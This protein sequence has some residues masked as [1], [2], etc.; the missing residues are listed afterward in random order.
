[1]DSAS[2][3]SSVEV[4]LMIILAASGINA[5]GPVHCEF[6][7]HE[8]NTDNPGD[9]AF[10]KMEFIELRK[11]FFTSNREV[12]QCKLKDYLL[13][14]VKEYSK[15]N[16]APQIVFSASF[17]HAKVTSDSNFFVI[18]SSRVANVNLKFDDAGVS[19]KTKARDTYTAKRTIFFP[20][21]NVLKNGNNYS[22][23][24]VIL[25][26]QTDYSRFQSNG[27]IAALSL[28]KYNA[29]TKRSQYLEDKTVTEDI[30]E[31]IYAHT[32]DMLIYARHTQFN[33][34]KFFKTVYERFQNYH[35][36]KIYPAREFD[37]TKHADLSIN[38][39]PD[40]LDCDAK[41]PLLLTNWKLGNVTPGTE[42]DCSGAHWL[43]EKEIKV[44]VDAYNNRT[45][46]YAYY[47]TENQTGPCFSSTTDIV[48]L[49]AIRDIE[50]DIVNNRDTAVSKGTDSVSLAASDSICRNPSLEAA[51][52]N[53]NNNINYLVQ[54]IETVKSLT[55]SKAC[56]K[57][58]PKRR[59]IDTEFVKPWEDDSQFQPQWAVQLKEYLSDYFDTKW[60]DHSTKTWMQLRID[61]RSPN[62]ATVHC[63]ICNQ[64]QSQKIFLVRKS[65][66]WLKVGDMFSLKT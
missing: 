57:A 54:E 15:M 33:D 58:T 29:I 36:D 3:Y 52:V 11:T 28:I 66:N 48:D 18:G 1:M 64:F 53:M 2:S 34:C 31:L 4:L 9:T 46:R 19:Y 41:S 43:L 65:L 32:V 12:S 50:V 44:V 7:I 23:M 56:D 8:V 10:E 40:M 26:K 61:I 13:I 39:C 16:D 24:A 35:G 6:R 27:S 45:G 51:I 47:T 55:V 30:K 20:E 59:R 38:R 21:Q 62:L 14:V 60:L 22:P 17:Y 42:N 37:K 63:K 49:S 25:L 5:D